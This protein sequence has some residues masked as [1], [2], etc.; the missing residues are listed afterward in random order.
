MLTSRGREFEVIDLTET[1]GEDAGRGG[2]VT[3]PVHAVLSHRAVDPDHQVVVPQDL[4]N[5][6]TRPNQGL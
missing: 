5:T 4:V 1:D 6:G 2:V 3:E